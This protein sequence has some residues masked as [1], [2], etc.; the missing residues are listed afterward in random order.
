MNVW[1][2]FFY[3]FP[4]WYSLIG[5]RGMGARRTHFVLNN[6]I[7]HDK[8]R[9]NR[10]FR[11]QNQ[12]IICDVI[13]VRGVFRAFA[14]VGVLPGSLNWN[15]Y[16]ICIRKWKAT[17]VGVIKLDK[18]E[19]QQINLSHAVT[20]FSIPTRVFRHH[21]GIIYIYIWCERGRERK[22]CKNAENDASLTMYKHSIN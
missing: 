19:N 15:G 13:T 18:T 7:W 1:V 8:C 17:R 22:R 5:W 9:L 4:F 12:H 2:C 21:L 11:L 16:K 20:S 6:R 14:S 3:L 10:I